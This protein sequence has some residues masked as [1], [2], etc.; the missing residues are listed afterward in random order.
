[1]FGWPFVIIAAPMGAGIRGDQLKD[2][3]QEEGYF[4]HALIKS[5]TSGCAGV[6]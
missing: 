4:N 5:F 2:T 3:A 6:A 1:M